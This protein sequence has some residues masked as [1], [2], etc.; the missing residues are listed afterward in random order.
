MASEKMAKT[1][2]S[3]A[4]PRSGELNS[5]YMACPPLVAPGLGPQGDIQHRPV[6]CSVTFGTKRANY[7]FPG[8]WGQPKPSPDKENGS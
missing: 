5:E 4:W 7:L 6:I 8:R 2:P 1:A 3:S